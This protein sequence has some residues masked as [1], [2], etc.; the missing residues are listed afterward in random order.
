[1]LLLLPVPAATSSFVAT[2]T[3]AAAAAAVVLGVVP[4][5]SLPAVLL[6]LDLL[7]L[8]A[9][10]LLL[11][12]AERPFRLAAALTP[13]L[14]DLQMR[15]PSGPG[16]RWVGAGR[17]CQQVH[18]HVLCTHMQLLGHPCHAWKEVISSCVLCTAHHTCVAR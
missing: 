16:S 8:V 12:L 2:A 15:V 17:G 9:G 18:T 1:M 13:V 10:V 3:A 4:E 6:F 5:P 11:V 7:L 14:V